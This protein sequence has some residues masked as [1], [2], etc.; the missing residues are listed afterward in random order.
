MSQTQPEWDVYMRIILRFENRWRTWRARD[1][2][3]P[4]IIIGVCGFVVLS[5]GFSLSPR[6]LSFELMNFALI[7][8]VER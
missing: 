5:F 2:A 6:Y 7:G 4:I 1:A 8:N 3:K